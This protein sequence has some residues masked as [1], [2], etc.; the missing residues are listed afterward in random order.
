MTKFFRIA[1]FVFATTGWLQT[2]AHGQTVSL[3]FLTKPTL[4]ECEPE[5]AEPCFRMKFDFV[6]AAGRPVN[7]QLPSAEE[8]AS[9]VEVQIDGQAVKPFY[10][11]AAAGNADQVRLPQ[12][13]LLLFDVSGSM[14]K[15]DL[16]GQSRFDAA[17]GAA[18][19][20]LRNFSD[21]HDRVAIVPFDSHNVES[22][23]SAAHFVSTRAEAQAELDALPRPAVR[24]NTALYSA[25]RAAVAVLRQQHHPGDEP[26]HLL[27][28]TDGANDVHPQSGDDQGLLAGSG[29]LGTAAAAVQQSGVDVLPIG[30]GNRQSIDEIAMTRLGTRPPLITFDVNDLRKAFQLVPLSQN[31]SLTVAVQA[32]ESLGSRTL[33]AG[34][35][36]HFRAKVT[37]PDGSTQM[38]NRQ[39]L[40][41]APPVATPSFEGEA[42]EA[43]Q[44]AFL[45]DAR[46]GRG[47][48]LLFL[49][50]FFVFAGFAVLLAILWFGLP[51][52]LWPERYD[53]RVA[54]PVRPEYWPG[55]ESPSHKEGHPGIRQAPPGFEAMA[56][57]GRAAIRNPEEHTIVQSITEFDPNK[58]RLS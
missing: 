19:E 13:A 42:T 29:G 11:A 20:Y 35:V 32:P 16:D 28:L 55:A 22:T 7:V 56:R 26:P 44:R 33:L 51:R 52:L 37:L 15:S 17:K 31:G 9:H 25:V 14:L 34:R 46:M 3:D 53:H 23:I 18:A 12:T 10:A 2:L 8:L 21:G 6:D 47:S 41:V 4:V 38:E 57:G 49:R 50:P 54:R 40:W 24:N 1:A 39:A 43:E 45:G 27:L 58:T 48:L 36:V 30:L 5:S